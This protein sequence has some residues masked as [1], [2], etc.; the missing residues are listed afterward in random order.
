M[1]RKEIITENS[2]MKINRN[3]MN[4]TNPNYLRNINLSN[5]SQVQKKKNKFNSY[6][7]YNAL[8]KQKFTN[9]IKK[10]KAKK[11][12]LNINEYKPKNRNFAIIRDSSDILKYMSK[13]HMNQVDNNYYSLLNDFE[14]KNK[15]GNTS[16]YL[17]YD[18]PKTYKGFNGVNTIKSQ[19]SSKFRFNQFLNKN[20]NKD[21][22]HN[23]SKI[24]LPFCVYS[25]KTTYYENVNNFNKSDNLEYV[26]RNNNILNFNFKLKQEESKNNEIP[27]NENN[28]NFEA[29]Q[30]NT[31]TKNELLIINKR[32]NIENDKSK[33][34]EKSNNSSKNKRNNIQFPIMPTNSEEN[35]DN[36]EKEESKGNED[37]EENKGNEEEEN[38][39]NGEEENKDNEEEENKDNEEEENEK[40]EE[41]KEEEEQKEEDKV[42]K[43]SNKEEVESNENNEEYKNEEESESINK[44]NKKT[45]ESEERKN[46]V[47]NSD[48][49]SF[50]ESENDDD[51]LFKRR[52]LSNHCINNIIRL[53]KYHK[54]I[55]ILKTKKF[56]NK[57]Q[58]NIKITFNNKKNDSKDN[59]NIIN[60]NQNNNHN[61]DKD[62][63]IINLNE[64]KPVK[65]ENIRLDG[66]FQNSRHY[67]KESGGSMSR[68]RKKKIKNVE[69]LRDI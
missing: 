67:N 49:I 13:D 14:V 68:S 5:N 6:D 3:I 55:N 32:E 25:Q 34:S 64:I 19:G 57:E 62:K 26:Y 22:K 39:D 33:K 8:N 2:R 20:K 66:R 11:T 61:Q 48:K 51:E 47:E 18:E 46:E 45:I 58:K 40:K 41:E 16:F 53:P 21:Y 65:I 42:E 37:E 7:N 24:S 59:I 60:N 36:E 43:E 69:F 50:G 30:N 35:K 54:K 23:I 17:I 56:N 4:Q 29:K 44:E 1:N 31:D 63:I 15:K 12:N 10:K 28:Y 52:D 27:I 38:K 9:Q